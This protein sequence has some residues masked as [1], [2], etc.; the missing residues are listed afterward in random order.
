MEPFMKIVVAYFERKGS[1]NP[2]VEAR[3][4]AAALDGICFHYIIDPK[5]FPLYEIKKRLY[6]F[7]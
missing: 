7:I 1:E 5:S 3:L 4:V 2:Y 6:Q